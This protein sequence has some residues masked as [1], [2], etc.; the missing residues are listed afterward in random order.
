MI[1][2]LRLKVFSL[3]LWMS[4]QAPVEH[5]TYET[6]KSFI[7]LKQFFSMLFDKFL[8]S[9]RFAFPLIVCL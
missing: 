2:K 6:Q 7:F 3:F 1:I 5:T 4:V 8:P 9:A